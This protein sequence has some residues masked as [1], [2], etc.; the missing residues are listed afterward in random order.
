MTI[1]CAAIVTC[2]PVLTKLLPASLATHFSSG[3]RSLFSLGRSSGGGGGGSSNRLVFPSAPR[4]RAATGSLAATRKDAV[5]A[6]SDSGSEWRKLDER[7]LPPIPKVSGDREQP[8]RSWYQA[9]TTKTGS[10]L[11]MV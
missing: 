4:G 11:E 1:A 3:W 10:D 2:R 7:P 9:G 6:G 8:A 5:S